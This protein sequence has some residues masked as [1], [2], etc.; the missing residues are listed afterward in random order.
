VKRKVFIHVN[1]TNPVLD[2]GSP[3]RAEIIAK[4]WDVAEDGMRVVL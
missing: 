1:T 4:G 3:E 2:E